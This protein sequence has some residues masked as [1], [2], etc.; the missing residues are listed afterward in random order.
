MVRK[1]GHGDRI[2]PLVAT[3]ERKVE[4]TRGGFGIVMEQL[5]EVT[6]A[7]EQERIGTRR[8]GIQILLHHR[9]DSH[10]AMLAKRP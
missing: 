5:I 1:A 2:L 4:H 8:F 3:G 10:S 9:A 6:H 7:K